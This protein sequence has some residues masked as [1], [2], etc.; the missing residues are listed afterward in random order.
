MYEGVEHGQELHHFIFVFVAE[1]EAL[2]DPARQK[3]GRFLY[4]VLPS[5]LV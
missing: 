5:L 1:S 4:L 3:V 2:Y